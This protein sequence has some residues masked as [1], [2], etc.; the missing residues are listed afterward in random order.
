MLSR[1]EEIL[2]PEYRDI[3]GRFLARDAVVFQQGYGYKPLVDEYG[4]LFRKWLREVGAD[5]PAEKKGFNRIYLTHDVDRPFR[6]GR[7]SLVIK[8]II[9]N[10][11]KLNYCANPIKKYSN[12]QYD[13]NYT[14]P[15]IIEYDKDLQKSLPEIPVESIYFF[16]TIGTFFNNKYYNFF[17]KKVNRLI[18]SLLES[19]AKIGLHISH[20]AGINPQKIQYDVQCYKIKFDEK[21]LIS[22]HHYLRWCE[23]EDIMYMEQ[24]GITDDF[25]LS[26]ADSAGFRAGTCRPY[27][28][29]NPK[30]K[31]L[32][33]VIIH[34]LE[35]MECS[36]S[37]K[38]YMNLEYEEAFNICKNIISQVY[39][40]N[41][42]LNLLW[43]NTEFLNLNYQEKLYKSIINY[44][45]EQ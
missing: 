40:N 6:F 19:G 18:T 43:H 27:Q 20:E 39:Y 24:A 26:Y 21:E 4:L 16:F 33:N 25:S 3:Y 10:L 23:P 11:I 9:K 15:K 38:E 12:E 17:S 44:I 41:G 13:D 32:S 37:H 28:F 45:K 35:V 29:I 34:P 5:V 7:F 22:R 42:E 2:K 30:T 14:F 36:L 1:Y 31:E 8:Q